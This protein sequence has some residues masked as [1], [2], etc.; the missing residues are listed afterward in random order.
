MNNK[1]FQNKNIETKIFENDREMEDFYKINTNSLVAGIIINP[2]LSSYTIRVDRAS[3][4]HSSSFTKDSNLRINNKSNDYLKLF[5]PLQMVIDQALIQLKTGDDSINMLA[6]IGE[7]PK[8][9][10]NEKQYLS[11]INVFSIFMVEMI[12]TIPI[13]NIVQ[14][15]VTEN[16]TKIKSYLISIGIHPSAFWLS[17]IFSNISYHLILSLLMCIILIIFKVFPIFISLIAFVLL[18][19]YCFSLINIGLLLSSLFKTAKTVNS[20][21]YIFLPLFVITYFL[22]HYCTKSIQLIMSFILSPVSFGLAIEKLIL[23]QNKS[24]SLISILTDKDILIFSICLI[25]NMILYFILAIIFDFFLSEEN[26]RFISLKIKTKCKLNEYDDNKNVQSIYQNDIE[27]YN[28]YES[29]YIEVK[30]ISKEYINYYNKFIAINNVSFK[31]Y[32]NEIFG[33]LGHHG[34]GKTTLLNIISKLL[35]PNNGVI[36]FDGNELNSNIYDIRQEMGK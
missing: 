22:F 3:I 10:I 20:A 28:G 27:E 18:C 9:E 1:L 6:N 2:N 31:A 35:Q 15:I 12:Y 8:K 30:N 24:S 17:W 23:I 19:I 25:W 29:S 4:P 34:A 32:K 21:S 14:F 26:Q 33:I 5:T 16:E 36:I 11:V 7:L 13:M